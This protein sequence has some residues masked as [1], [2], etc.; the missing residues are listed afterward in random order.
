MNHPVFQTLAPEQEER[1]S[2]DLAEI[3]QRNALLREVH[4][5]NKRYSGEARTLLEMIRS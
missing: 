2:A 3:E 5:Y 4:T 1:D